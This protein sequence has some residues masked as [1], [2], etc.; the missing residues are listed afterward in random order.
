MRDPITIESTQSK[1]KVHRASGWL[2]SISLSRCDRPND[3]PALPG[4]HGTRFAT[5]VTT[6]CPLYCSYM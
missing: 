1:T 5:L 6:G 4:M 2:L 3:G